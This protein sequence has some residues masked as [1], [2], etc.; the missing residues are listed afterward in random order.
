MI[1]RYK[2][3]KQADI[4]S[5]KAAWAIEWAPGWV[6]P[7]LKSR[8][9]ERVLRKWKS[10][11]HMSCSRAYATTIVPATGYLCQ[12][13]EAG[14]A[15]FGDSKPKCPVVWNATVM[16]SSVEK[17]KT[18]AEHSDMAA[19]KACLRGAALLRH[20]LGG[21]SNSSAHLVINSSLSS[22]WV[23]VWLST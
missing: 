15:V 9:G 16:G 11:T 14:P 4:V 8:V 20:L 2:R 6:T 21:I 17:G 12:C 23:N 1:P 19:L 3:L 10:C 18:C 13:G 7:C 5:S 22:P